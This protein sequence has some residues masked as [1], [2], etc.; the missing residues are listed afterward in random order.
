MRRCVLGCLLVVSA[1][2]GTYE[3]AVAADK[4][5]GYAAYKLVWQRN[6]FDPQ[7]RAPEPE[8]SRRSSAPATSASPRTPSFRLSGTMV[9]DGRLLAFF[10]GSSSDFNKVITTGEKIA[11]FTVKKIDAVE[12]ELTRGDQTY[13]LGLGQQLTM[14]ERIEIGAA[15]GASL[16]SSPAGTPAGGESSGGPPPATT[17]AG[18][19]ASAAPSSNSPASTGIDDVRRRMEER[20]KQQ[21]NK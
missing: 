7:R 12:V 11:D 4:P 16:A 15:S 17:S 20:R 21:M 6:I 9:S 8:R 10:G 3:H 2:L 19:G 18:D 5:A 14:G 13:Q 1:L